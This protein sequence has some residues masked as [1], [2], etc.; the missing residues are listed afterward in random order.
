[1]STQTK[2][3]AGVVIGGALLLGGYLAFFNSSSAPSV[4]S[5]DAAPASA[6]EITFLDLATKAEPI[7]F[8][9]SILFDP[10]FTALI[11]TRTAIVPVPLGRRD[12]FA[13]VAGIAT[14][15]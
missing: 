7:S 10:R 4:V 12:P 14:G 5:T 1:M 13:P 6:A 15:N 3:I 11:D 2:I 8:D 9:T